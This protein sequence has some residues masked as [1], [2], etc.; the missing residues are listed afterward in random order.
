MV[1]SYFQIDRSE[2]EINTLCQADFSGTTCGQIADVAEQLNLH[3][4]VLM[5]ITVDTLKQMLSSKLP[6]IALI[7]GGI[8]YGGIPGFG[9]FIVII[10]IEGREIVYHDPEIGSNCRTRIADLLDAWCQFEF[11]GVKIW[12]PERK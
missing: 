8:L 7:D 5:N 4:E 3:S 1:L 11:L 12:K 2:G 6:L 9:H 10:G